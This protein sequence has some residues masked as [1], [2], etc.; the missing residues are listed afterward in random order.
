MPKRKARPTFPSGLIFLAV[1]AALVFAG[2]EVYRRFASDG[3]RLAMARYFKVGDPARVTALVGRQIHRGLAAMRVPEDSLRDLGAG[4]GAGAAAGGAS[5]DATGAPAVRWR[6]GLSPDQSP[7]QVNYAISHYIE[8]A[9]GAVL[10]GRESMGRAGETI[11]TMLVGLPDRATHELT[12]V[13]A[14][15]REIEAAPARG[16]LALV[17]FGLADDPA[18]AAATF[19]LS[20]PFAVA[21]PPGTAGSTALYRG[22]HAAGREVVLHLPLEPINYPQV[23]PGPGTVLVTM[24]PAEITGLTRRYLDQADPVAAVANA[25]G[26]LATQDMT[27]MSAV[28][29]ELRRRHVPFIHTAPVAG[30]VCRPLAAQLGVIY[31]QPDAVIDAEARRPDA[32]ALDRRWDEVLAAARKRGHAIVWLRLTPVAREWLPRAVEARRLRDLDLVPLSSLIRQPA[33]L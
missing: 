23:N 13:R 21:I 8:E 4:R 1:A 27:V 17:L 31:E 14:G 24:K 5:G 33:V 18:L 12:L 25:M 22:A 30:A 15:R 16:R 29:R 3:G 2:G 32:R 6:I 7:L 9:G 20:V 28:Y 19:A 26:S 11:V 10:A